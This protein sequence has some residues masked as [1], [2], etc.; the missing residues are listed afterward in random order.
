MSNNK[1]IEQERQAFLDFAAGFSDE[2][3][4][5]L[6]IFYD[7]IVGKAVISYKIKNRDFVI[8][9]AETTAYE[10][11]LTFHGVLIEDGRHPREI[12]MTAVR[13]EKLEQG[14]R[15]RF[16]NG[17]VTEGVIKE[18]AFTFEDVSAR[19]RL[20]NYNFSTVPFTADTDKI[21]WRLICEPIDAFVDK[22]QVLG[23]DS[24]NEY[25]IEYAVLFQFLH[26]YIGLYLHPETR[27]GYGRTSITYD[28]DL[29]DRCILSKRM[30]MAAKRLFTSCE[31][32]ELA[33][34]L[35]NYEEHKRAFFEAWA[36]KITRKEG[37][38]LYDYLKEMIDRCCRDYPR[39]NVLLPIYAGNHSYVKET[40]EELFKS[41]GFKG[42]FPNYVYKDRPKF[43][44]TSQV[45]ERKY[46]YVNEKQ[47]VVLYSFI[48]SVVDGGILIYAVRGCVLSKDR[49]ERQFLNDA[50]YC[51]FT[52]GGRRSAK[53]TE[54]L[55][56]TPEMT[57]EEIKQSIVE[58]FRKCISTGAQNENRE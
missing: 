34:L 43:I 9:V 19:I 53:L 17:L 18:S 12:L 56:I 47:K 51:Y 29:I 28:R 27:I 35:E 33:A 41:R 31:W 26:I 58:F 6:T 45:Y 42:T 24:L 3:S 5:V 10:L 16:I 37:R 21:P 4:K 15:L 32:T 2:V 40:L 14:Y 1:M 7:F 11:T 8:R 22:W 20:W 52:D 23:E 25:E 55:F 57:R 38:I 13:G 54:H 39:M 30:L 44:E 46:T 49:T 36:Y 50:L 48:E